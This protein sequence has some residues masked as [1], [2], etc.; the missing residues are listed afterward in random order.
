MG[1]W[2]DVPLPRVRW[3]DDGPGLR[4][5]SVTFGAK[6]G[7]PLLALGVAVPDRWWDPVDWSGPLTLGRVS[8]REPSDGEAVDHG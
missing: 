5:L 3:F 4:F 7:D 8:C 6:F 2:V 1:R